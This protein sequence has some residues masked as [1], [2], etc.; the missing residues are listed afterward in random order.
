VIGLTSLLLD[1]ELTDEQQD[2][3]ST[4]R[5][6]GDGLLTIINDIL[7]FSKIEAGRLE[8]EEQPFDLR[9][10]IEDTLDLLAPKAVSKNLN[11]AYFMENNLPSRFIG[12]VTRLRQILVNLVG[13]AI[14]FTK[15]GE[16]VVFVDGRR[17]TESAFILHLAVK[18]TGIGIPTERMDRLFR[19]FSQVD[20]STTRNYGG[21][22]L[23]L[24]ISKRLTE[25]MGGEMWVE[26]EVGVGSTFHFTVRLPKAAEQ[27]PPIDMSEHD[28]LRDRRLLIVDD[29]GTNRM[30]ISRQAL[31]WQL[32]PTAVPSGSAAL[33][34]L[35]EHDYDAAILDMQ[36]PQ[37]D[38]NMLAAAIRQHPR[39]K[40][41]PLILLTSLGLP[42]QEQHDDFEAR[43][44]KPV[45]PSMLFDT[46]VN[47]FAQKVTQ[48]VKTHPPTSPG[49]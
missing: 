46:L 36:M 7:D 45:K 12:D 10:C 1:T 16:V 21:T 47:L 6:S 11:I 35:N 37:M 3:V 44:T 49:V 9:S 30:I 25:M 5:N 17:E 8:L 20:A 31:S 48:P 39:G 42:R 24:V 43:L 13:N 28:Y 23:G 14:K 4:I 15:K 34:L 40:G 29:N 33:D 19:S 2:F 38:G 41:I 18:D 26:S 32:R 22:G 27:Q